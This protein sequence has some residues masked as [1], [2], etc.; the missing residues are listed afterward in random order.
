MQNDNYSISQRTDFLNIDDD[1]KAILREMTPMIKSI[2]PN[3][4]DGFYNHVRAWSDVSKFF[5]NEAQMGSAKNA[6]LKHWTAIAE[7]EFSTEYVNSV[8]RIGQAHSRIGLEPRWYIGGYTFIITEISKAIIAQ[9][10]NSKSMFGKSNIVE[11]VQQQVSAFTKA[12]MLD[13]DFA[14]SIYLEEETIKRDNLVKTIAGKFESSVSKVV[15]SV[16]AASTELSVTSKAM[17]EIAESSSEKATNVAAAAEQTNE[18]VMIIAD[19]SKEMSA[20]VQEIASQISMNTKSASN[21]VNMVGHSVNTLHELS[22]AS[23]KI[24]AVVSLIADIAS[25][26]NLLA[27][28]ATIESARAGEAGKGFS[29][30]ATEVKNLAGQTALATEEISKQIHQMQSATNN[31]VDAISSI[32]KTIEEINSVSIAINA[33]IEEQTSTTAE[34]SRNTQEASVGTSM[35]S[36]DIVEITVSS[37]E[38][39]AAARDVVSAAYDLSKQ[40][41]TLRSEV[42]QFIN[43][44]L[45]A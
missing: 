15:E 36:R 33:A 28:N 24:G 38:T 1:S 27:L 25:Q 9:I 8:R 19:S 41:E 17:S 2:L 13:M 18:N 14:I 10:N 39:G 3:I 11:K 45:V 4:L 43:E 44:L 5:A 22:A 12:A 31:A 23:E 29:V 26:T 34:I 37:E 7:G 21:A 30:V 40:A 32:Q 20:S 16:A 35:V 42:E 6:Q